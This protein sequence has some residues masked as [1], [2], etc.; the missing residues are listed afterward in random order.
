[1]PA[2]GMSLAVSVRRWSGK[3]NRTNNDEVAVE[4]PLQIRMA[5]EDVAVT[6]RTPG[7][8][9]ELASGFLFTEGIIK[10]A[11]DIEQI[12]HC[13]DDY[14]IPSPNVVNVQPANRELLVPHAWGRSFIAAAGCGLC[15]KTSISQVVRYIKKVSPP[16][17][18]KVDTLYS[19]PDK[20]RAAQAAFTQTGGL[21]A[22]GLFT[23]NGDLLLLRE[24]V[25]R[26]NAVDKVIGHALL[27]ESLPLSSNI[28]LVSSRA[29]FEI[30]QKALVA[31]LGYL[32]VISAPSSLAVKLARESGMT[33]V[34]FL[35]E[36]RLNVYAGE[37]WI[38]A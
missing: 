10:G 20:L 27:N 23:L 31:G 29:S 33:L 11:A 5:G 14:G 24:D 9:L 36:G 16:G 15:G 1:M 38:E 32:A 19:L 12:G 6:M 3:V 30:V 22:A 26:H 18:L 37:E 7:H 34:A 28:L 4:E 17:P 8:D 21:H 13:P 25:G 35:R 2:E